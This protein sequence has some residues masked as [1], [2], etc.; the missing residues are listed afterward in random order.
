MAVFRD[1]Q[2]IKYIKVDSNFQ[3]SICTSKKV[4]VAGVLKDNFGR[5]TG[6]RH[7]VKLCLVAFLQFYF[8]NFYFYK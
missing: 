5:I 4:K 6:Y 2:A 3:N 1:T 8:Y 7:K